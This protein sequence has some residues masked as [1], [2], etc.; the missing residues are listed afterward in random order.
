MDDL[1]AKVTIDEMDRNEEGLGLQLV[2]QV[3]IDQ[4]IQE[5][6][7]HVFSDISLPV[8][9]RRVDSLSILMTV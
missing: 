9:I 4:P 6:W 8:K 5:H 1:A 2:L 7:S 3:D